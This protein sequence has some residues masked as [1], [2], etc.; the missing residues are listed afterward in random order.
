MTRHYLKGSEDRDFGNQIRP[1]IVFN[2]GVGSPGGGQ[3][4]PA[5][6]HHQD[7]R[8]RAVYPTKVRH[9]SLTFRVWETWRHVRSLT[10]HSIIDA[11][12]EGTGNL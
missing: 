2:S 12:N 7:P 6:P 5:G 11:H 4:T 10:I 1:F 8:A 9:T 3:V